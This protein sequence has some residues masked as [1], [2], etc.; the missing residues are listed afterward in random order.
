MYAAY[1][2]ATEIL[3]KI[4]IKGDDEN[5]MAEFIGFDSVVETGILFHETED[6]ITLA[7]AKYKIVNILPSFGSK[8][9]KVSF[10]IYAV[11]CRSSHGAEK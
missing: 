9:R 7:N 11:C 4:I 6:D 5:I 1:N 2:P 8:L 3:R 10:S